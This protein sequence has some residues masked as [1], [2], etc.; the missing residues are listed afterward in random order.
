MGKRKRI[1][2]LRSYI[3][4]CFMLIII[5]IALLSIAYFEPPGG[6]GSA[7]KGEEGIIKEGEIKPLTTATSIKP[8]L[9]GKF[10][11]EKEIKKLKVETTEKDK[12]LKELKKEISEK[13]RKIKK[14]EGKIGKEEKITGGVGKHEFT[15]L[16][17]K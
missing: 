3:D 16:R 13:E 4:F 17:K 12:L 11:Y 6:A 14:L 9:E 8:Y 2:F 5:L 10:Y 7:T 15:D 1:T